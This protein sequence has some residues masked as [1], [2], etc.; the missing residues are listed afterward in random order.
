[1]V[2]SR[3]APPIAPSQSSAWLHRLR[4]DRRGNVPVIAGATALLL[5][6]MCMVA[7]DVGKLYLAKSGAQRIADHFALAAALAYSQGSDEPGVAQADS[8][9]GAGPAVI[10]TAIIH[11]PRNDGNK[12]AMA[13]V[14]QP[15]SLSPLFGGS[16]G[17]LTSSSV[18]ASAYAEIQDFA[19]CVIGIGAGGMTMS[20]RATVTATGCS[21]SSAGGVSVASGAHL[22]AQAVQASGAISAAGNSLTTTPIDGQQL[23]H[24]AIP[25]DPYAAAGLFDRLPAVAALTAAG[26]PAVG[27]PPGSGVARTCN[28]TLLLHAGKYGTISAESARGCTAITFLGGGETD[29]AGSGLLLAGEALTVTFCPGLYKING[30]SA[31][32][33]TQAT[34]NITSNPAICGGAKGMATLDVWNG[35]SVSGSA[36]LTVNGPATYNVSGG[37]TTTSTAPLTFTNDGIGADS[38]FNVAGGIALLQGGTAMFPDGTYT[39]TSG[40][41]GREG[42]ADA[43]I[44]VGPGVTAIFGNGSFNIAHGINVAGGGALVFGQPRDKDAVFRIPSA[45]GNGRA[46]TTAGRSALT[47]G[48]FAHADINGPVSFGGDVFFGAG[49]YTINGAVEAALQGGCCLSGS[50]MS[51]VAAGPITIGAGYTSV[52]LNAPAAIG[53]SSLGS[54]P[55][56]VLASASA[57][58]ST[59]TVGNGGMVLLGAIYTPNAPLRLAGAGNLSGGGG[60]TVFDVASLA[61]TGAGGITTNCSGLISIGAARASL[62]Q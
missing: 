7:I 14:T 50:D 22:E 13:V 45:A 53:T 12:A 5:I 26:F 48:G 17:L 49:S 4:A 29:I 6:A 10:K 58:P 40:D 2:V 9:N 51:I 16:L 31:A 3:A 56:V 33:R 57:S 35:I 8:G 38:V 60:C 27:A 61:I 19:P 23:Q 59:I 25:A 32:G 36:A 11:T 44:D 20:E 21:I 39:V 47:F 54:A 30:I 34:L 42:A 52:D 28:G 55:T 18:S 43:G 41:D 24:A 1:M 46:I 15:V 37:I 62:V